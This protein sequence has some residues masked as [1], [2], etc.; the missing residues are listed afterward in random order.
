MWLNNSHIK[1]GIKF[2]FQILLS[3]YTEQRIPWLLRLQKIGISSTEQL[4][5][6]FLFLKIVPQ[7]NKIEGKLDRGH[8]L[9]EYKHFVFLIFFVV[10]VVLS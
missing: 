10:F 3:E 8:E 9:C 7:K 6:L 1:D 4:Y 2:I 5:D